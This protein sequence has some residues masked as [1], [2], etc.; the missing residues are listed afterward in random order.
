MARSIC[1][2]GLGEQ[3]S[4]AMAPRLNWVNRVTLASARTSDH[5]PIPMQPTRRGP[6]LP[7]FTLRACKEACKPY[8]VPNILSPSV[9]RFRSTPMNGHRQSIPACRVGAN[10]LNRC[11]IARGGGGAAH[12]YG[13]TRGEMVSSV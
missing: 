1:F 8:F 5:H 2:G 10:T 13:S 3:R 4:A 7:T 9:G 6:P 12:R 11:A